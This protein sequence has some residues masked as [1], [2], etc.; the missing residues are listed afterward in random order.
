MTKRKSQKLTNEQRKC[1][2]D[3]HNRSMPATEISKFFNIPVTTVRTVISIFLKTGRIE[4]IKSGGPRNVKINNE[5]RIKIRRMVEEDACVTLKQIKMMVFNDFNLNICLATIYRCLD[6]FH[7][8]W[9]KLA[10]IPI[11]RNIDENKEARYIYAQTYFGFLCEISEENIIFVDEIGFNLSM[12][13]HHG[14]SIIGTTPYTMVPNV[15]S[16]NFSVCCAM[17]KGGLLFKKIST[18]A[19]NSES[20]LGYIDDL[21]IYLTSMNLQQCLIIMDNVKFHKS[22]GV[23]RFFEQ[24]AHK[25]LFLPPYSPFINPIENMFSKWKNYVR[26]SSPTNDDELRSAIDRGLEN[27]TENDCSGFYREM[28]RNLSKC[29]ERQDF[30]E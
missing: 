14:R 13:S 17:S 2:I 30:N 5:I 15:R 6:S 12:R 10:L 22:R 19:F 29:L 11:R 26:R 24:S 8:S 18:S 23:I 28:L 21:F 16:R 3:N 9:K 1:I 27:I 25:L 20:F 7:F 4:S